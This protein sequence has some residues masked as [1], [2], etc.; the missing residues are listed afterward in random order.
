MSIRTHPE[1]VGKFLSTLPEQDDHPYRTGPWRP[2]TTEWD[3]DDLTV[4]DGQIPP[5]LDG[6]YLRN[7]ENPLHPALKHYH[8]FDGDGMLHIV[9]FRDGKAFYR[10]RFVRT[11]AF[12]EENAAGGPL[13]PGIGEPIELARRD[14][15]W[16]ARTLMKDSSST[17]V[18][19]HRG[20]ALT[21]HYQCGDL[22]RTDPYTG[23]ALGKEDWYGAF[24]SA[25][26]VSAHPKVDDRTGELLYFSYSKQAPH[27]RYGVVDDTGHVVHRVDVPLPGPRL[28]HDM[29]FTDNY[30]I[31]NDF[32]MFWDPALL[33]HNVHLPG[34]HSDIPSRFAV[35]PRRGDTTQIRW[36]EA[37][38]TYVLHFPN[39]YEDGDEI[40][41]DGFFQ[42]DP[43]PADD[44]LGDKWARRFRFLAM[45][46]MQSRL[47]RWR[48]NLVTGEVREQQ[49]S[50]SISEFGM[51]NPGYAGHAYR[52]TY[53]A[54][55]KP[56]WFLFDGLVRHDLQT[57]V[58]ERYAF[59]D[60]VFGSETAMAP[61]S[62]V[63]AGE[64]DGYLV[65]LTTDMAA[66][67]SYCLVFDAARVG[68]GPVCKLALP[69]RVSS[70]THATWAAGADLRRWR[71][72]DSAAASIGL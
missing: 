57:G 50:D 40:V 59:G 23:K 32:P 8:P 9:G 31:L 7:T 66:D 53:A 11:D 71:E 42:S 22:Y 38:P 46:R 45:D 61:R 21:S 35:I 15:G 43:E 68:D 25:W 18:V 58:E 4:V 55:A 44:G 27:L 16:G 19:V 6:V 64:D 10:N 14:Y 17:D 70:G 67:A 41:L 49:M 33:E 34:F 2:Q 48:F 26:G 72:T 54:T 39:A 1:V 20:T 65:T 28:P 3:A 24:P 60:G 37:D 12:S 30:V 69:E 62:G 36:F 47:H 13:W 52:Y 56:G 29:A 63:A 51:I 5:D